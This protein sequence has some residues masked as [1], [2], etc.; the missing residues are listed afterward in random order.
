[1]RGLK[2]WLAQDQNHSFTNALA[3]VEKWAKITRGITTDA[4]ITKT[5]VLYAHM[6]VYPIMNGIHHVEDASVYLI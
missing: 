2:I 1:M 5:L 6:D 3:K 4:V